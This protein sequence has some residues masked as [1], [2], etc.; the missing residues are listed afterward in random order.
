MK[1]LIAMLLVLVFAMSLCACGAK[2]EG[3]KEGG[4]DNAETAESAVMSNENVTVE[5][6]YVDSSYT[7][8][9]DSSIKMVYVFLNVKA[10]DTNLDIDSSY[11]KLTINDANTYESTFYKGACDFA[12]SYYYSSFIEDV[13]VGNEAKLALTFKVPEGDLTGGKA[14]KLEDT[15]IPF[16]D[17]SFTTDE[18]VFCDSPE[19]VG[20]QA[21]PAGYAEAADKY[22]PAD[23]ET[24]AMVKEQIN[25]YYW[26]FYVSAGTMVQRQEIEF[27]APNEF[28]VRSS[29]GANGGT[30]EITKGYIRVTYST[31]NETY[32]IPYEFV[33]GEISLDCNAAFSIYE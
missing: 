21:D 14:I 6:I 29:F 30:Y 25:G 17:I 19:N 22:L 24:E 13:Y 20:E 12:P 26:E 23:A 15:S 1:K 4:K 33:D 3:N 16:E 31:N 5:G 9:D 7:D 2:T 8:D 28:E 11:T 27:F 10:T 18:I 32:N